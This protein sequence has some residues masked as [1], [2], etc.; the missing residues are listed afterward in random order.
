MLTILMTSTLENQ[1][2]NI[3]IFKYIH[4]LYYNYNIYLFIYLYVI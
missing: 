4:I 2:N 3:Y 1:I